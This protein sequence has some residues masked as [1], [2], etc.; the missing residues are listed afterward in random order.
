[1]DKEFIMVIYKFCT[2]IK[3]TCTYNI[4]QL[5]KILNFQKCHLLSK[6][7]KKKSRS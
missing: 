3:L 5:K 4:L 6:C 1:L 2:N 7:L